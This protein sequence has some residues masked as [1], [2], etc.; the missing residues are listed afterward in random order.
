MKV[1]L[2]TVYAGPRGN[3]GPGAV[4]DLPDKEAQGL[5]DGEYAEKFVEK[6]KAPPPKDPDAL[7]PEMARF[8]KIK[9]AVGQMLTKLD[10][11]GDL[12]TNDGRPK[13]PAL[14]AILGF[15]VTAD[16]RDAACDQ[17]RE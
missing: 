3:C 15:D 14:E 16:E 10:R 6:P 7:P 4:I 2:K 17:L 8:A 12:F 13:V 9:A 11:K 5:I 1:K